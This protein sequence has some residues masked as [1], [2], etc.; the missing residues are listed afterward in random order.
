MRKATLIILLALICHFS[1]AQLTGHVN[2]EQLGISF[3]IPSGWFGQEAEGMIV[4]GSNTTPGIVLLT[5]HNYS[6]QQLITEAKKGIQ[7]QGT[8][9]NLVGSLEMLGTNGVGGKFSGTMEYESSSAYIIGIANPYEGPGV[10]IMAATLQNM[11]SDEHTKVCKT[12]YQSVKFKKI[13]K[14]AELA[15]WKKWLSNVRLTYMDSYYS[16][17]YSAGGVSGGYSTE[18][19]IDLCSK[20]YFNYG[21]SSDMSVS[22][23]GV[24]GYNSGS[25]SGQGSWN[26]VIGATGS[27]TLILNFHNGEEYT[28]TLEYSDE[29]LYLNGDRYFRTTEGEYAPNCY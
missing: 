10:T 22:G 12:I 5:T 13:D 24:S 19:K 23:S 11:Y 26:I 17:D 1:K 29:K 7:E 8:N 2:L 4:L 16:S 15:E 18:R 14:S 6:K 9:M 21:S 20:G 28:Y 27:A 3:D 25:N